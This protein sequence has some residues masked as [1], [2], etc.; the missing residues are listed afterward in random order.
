[1]FAFVL[2]VVCA[3]GSAVP[4]LDIACMQYLEAT[5]YIVEYGALVPRNPGRVG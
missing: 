5:L 4:E 2:L 3:Q 1:M